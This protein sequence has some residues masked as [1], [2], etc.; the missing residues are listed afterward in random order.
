MLYRSSSVQKVLVP[1]ANP[2]ANFVKAILL[3]YIK[4]AFLSTYVYF[5]INFCISESG[6]NHAK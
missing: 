3:N 1:D 2:V 4:I 6:W 5:S